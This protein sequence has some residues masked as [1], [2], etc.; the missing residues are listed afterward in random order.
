MIGKWFYEA[1]FFFWWK[2]YMVRPLEKSDLCIK[3]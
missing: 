3:V 1:A 2:K